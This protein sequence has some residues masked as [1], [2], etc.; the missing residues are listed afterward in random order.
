LL[1]FQSLIA[2]QALAEALVLSASTST[3][4]TTA[5]RT[6][7]VFSAKD[8]N[9]IPLMLGAPRNLHLGPG[10]NLYDFT[11]APNLAQ[12]HVLAAIN[13][14]TIPPPMNSA[15]GKPF[16]V[17]NAEPLPFRVFL[18]MLWTEFDGKEL[19]KGISVPTKVAV[20]MTRFSEKIAG[21]TGKK[22]VL[23]VKDLGDSLAERWFDC[24]RAKEVLGWEP[25]VSIKD[26][27]KEAAEE[28]KRGKKVGVSS[29]PGNKWPIFILARNC[30]KSHDFL[31]VWNQ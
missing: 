29:Q 24:K 31:S 6:H 21:W 5:L 27:L 4:P 13:L 10:T 14:L 19:E 23:T 26:G 3:F 28:S 18:K 25:L 30:H 22:P 11:Y 16:F 7:A 12:A 17:T 8:T 2:F 9:L 1:Q 20:V 15:A